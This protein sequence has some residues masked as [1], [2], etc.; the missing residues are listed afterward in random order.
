MGNF[1]NLKSVGG[2]ILECKV[3]Y[4]PGYRIYLGRDGDTLVILLGGGTKKRQST[5]ILDARIHWANYKQRKRKG[6]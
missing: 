5:D 1:S 3:E 2:G 4:G 6:V